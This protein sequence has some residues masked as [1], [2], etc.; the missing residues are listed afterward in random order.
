MKKLA[1]GL[2]LL[3]ALAMTSAHAEE[4]SVGS[5]VGRG[6]DKG[7]QATAKGIEKGAEAT[8]KGVNK[9]A[10]ATGRGMKKADEWLSNKLHLKSRGASGP[11][12]NQSP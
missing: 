2:V 1:Q 10:E 9:A 4:E 11:A 7:A 3:A 12:Q 6:I 8:G 5:K